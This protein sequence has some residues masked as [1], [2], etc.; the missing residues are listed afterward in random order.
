VDL[1]VRECPFCET[2][3]PSLKFNVPG[4][5]LWINLTIFEKSDTE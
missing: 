1:V 4:V 2:A 3:L 5:Y